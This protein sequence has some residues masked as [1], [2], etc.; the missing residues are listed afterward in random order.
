[1]SHVNKTPVLKNKS[2]HLKTYIQGTYPKIA[3]KYLEQVSF[4]GPVSLEGAPSPSP[5]SFFVFS[6]AEV[7]RP[8]HCHPA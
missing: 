4:A 8:I 2:M 7:H 6:R 5:E 1:M 3:G